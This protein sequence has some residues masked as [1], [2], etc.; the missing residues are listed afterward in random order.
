MAFFRV[1]PRAGVIEGSVEHHFFVFLYV[2]T[3]AEKGGQVAFNGK[4]QKANFRVLRVEAHGLLEGFGR[5]LH[6]GE[7]VEHG[8]IAGANGL[9]SRFVAQ[10]QRVAVLVIRK[11]L[12]K[13]FAGYFIS[14]GLLVVA[15]QGSGVV[16]GR[17]RH[18]TGSVVE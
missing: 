1:E 9:G 2:L 17:G 11:Q 8:R 18:D 10:H 5:V 3:Q 4:A 6:V 14:G 12:V 13:F 7:L 16:R 15:A